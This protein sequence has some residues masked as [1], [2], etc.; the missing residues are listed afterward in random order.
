MTTKIKQRGDSGYTVSGVGVTSCA[1]GTLTPATCDPDSCDASAAP[2][3]G[4]KGTCT[5]T[6]PS[7]STCQPICDSGYTVSGDTSCNAGTLTPA[8]C[9]DV[10]DDCNPNPCGLGFAT[11]LDGANS[12]SC[13]CHPGYGVGSDGA[14]VDCKET[15]QWNNGT[16]NY[17]CQDH[18]ECAINRKFT[19]SS[20]TDTGTCTDCPNGHT[21]P[22]IGF[23]TTCDSP[24]TV[25]SGNFVTYPLSIL[26]VSER[27]IPINVSLEINTGPTLQCHEELTVLLLWSTLHA[28]EL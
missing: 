13:T 27:G 15:Q 17:P 2:S 19:Y 25:C 14:C 1:T 18:S 4:N 16:D 21:T 6:L 3:N 22:S 8:T 20:S 24:S 10:T 23:H 12:F 5:T 28:K 9:T 11:C 26:S 7:G